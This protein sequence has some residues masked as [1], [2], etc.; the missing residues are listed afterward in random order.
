[1]RKWMSR[2]TVL[3]AL[4]IT[5]CV[6]HATPVYNVDRAS[7][8]TSDAL[9][10]DRAARAIKTAGTKLGWDMA[11]VQPGL[12]RGTLN[13]RKH[14]AVVDIDYDGRGYS[15]N[16]VESENLNYDP[17][18]LAIHKNYNS[19]IHNLERQIRLESGNV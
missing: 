2:A 7:Y 17:E 6:S 18:K 19:W 3:V 15:I 9:D 14:H 11:E 4:A 8:N 16:Y 12:I 13:V 10:S 5:A 1:M